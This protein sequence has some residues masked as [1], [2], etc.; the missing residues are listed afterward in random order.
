[1]K[2]WQEEVDR[3]SGMREEDFMLKG[4]EIGRGYPC[5]SLKLRQITTRDCLLSLRSN[6]T[7]KLETEREARDDGVMVV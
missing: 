5:K 4:W 3:K 7:C 6:E 2:T 1:M